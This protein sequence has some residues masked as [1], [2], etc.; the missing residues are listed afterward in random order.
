MTGKSW[1]ERGEWDW[2]RTSRRE[3]NSVLIS[4]IYSQ[5]TGAKAKVTIKPAQHVFRGETVTL[6]CDIYAEGVTRWRYTWYKEGSISVFSEQQEHTF[7]PVKE[8]DA[9]K[10]SCYG[11]ETEGSRISKSDEITLTVSVPRAVLS[12][13]PQTWLTEGDSVTPICE[14]NGS[15]TGWTFSWFTSFIQNLRS[16]F[17]TYSVL[18]WQFLHIC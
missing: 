8:V 18:Y 6:R 10:Y 7:S 15:S 14:V 5:H 17:S 13:S 12:V 16:L 3:S 4:N 9:G 2:Q 1:E 11:E